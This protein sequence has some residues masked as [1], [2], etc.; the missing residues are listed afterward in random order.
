MRRRKF[1]QTAQTLYFGF[2]QILGKDDAWHFDFNGPLPKRWVNAEYIYDEMYKCAAENCTIEEILTVL[3]NFSEKG[4]KDDVV[5]YLDR[6]YGSFEG[7]ESLFREALTET[8][9]RGLSHNGIELK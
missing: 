2:V 7:N 9:R 1:H 6:E 5:S 3:C 8:F 4:R